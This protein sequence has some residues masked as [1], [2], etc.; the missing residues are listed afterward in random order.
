MSPDSAVELTV[1]TLGDSVLDCRHYNA[2]GL[3]PGQLLVRNA[4]QLF[5]E[6]RGRDLASRRPVRLDHRAIDGATV[7]DLPDQVVGLTADEPS[8]ALLSVGGNDLMAGLLADG[9]PGVEAFAARLQRFLEALTVRPVYVATVY[10]PTFG[11]DRE[12][13][14]GVDPAIG[15]ANH[16]RVNAVLSAAGQRFGAVV[17]LHAHFLTG[18]PTW[19]TQTIEP[20]LRGASEIRRAFL[21][22][23]FA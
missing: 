13:F 21:E 8:I 12:P 20:S 14:L 6:F 2:F 18:D 9:G 23:I 11:D 5:P 17:D 22:R 15:R 4:D 19:F 3:E 7:E 10:D 16:R 1:V